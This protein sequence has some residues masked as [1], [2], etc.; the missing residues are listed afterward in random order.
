MTTISTHVLDTTS[1]QPAAGLTVRL[2][3]GT[4]EI[5]NAVTDTNGRCASLVPQ[6][7]TLAP[8]IFRLV[9]DVETR[10]PNGFYPE[11]SVSFLVRDPHAHYHVPLLVSPFGYTTYRGS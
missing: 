7:L 4:R 5:A 1:G 6:G 3:E 8:G 10:F 2:F 9:F 11:V